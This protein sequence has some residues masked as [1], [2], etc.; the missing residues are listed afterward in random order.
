MLYL[1]ITYEGVI[2]VVVT[3][4]LRRIGGSLSISVPPVILDGLH[5]EAGDELAIELDGERA[6]LTRA[7]RPPTLDELLDLCDPTAA[8][9]PETDTWLGRVP[10]GRE[11]L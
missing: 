1:Y 7:K 10:Q 5:V 8:E 2:R 4:K 9:D 6:I 11:L 3:A